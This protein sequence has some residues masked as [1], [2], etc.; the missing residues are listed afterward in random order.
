MAKRRGGITRRRSTRRSTCTPTT[1]SARRAPR[2]AGTWTSTT[3]S[4]RIPSTRAERRTRFTSQACEPSRR[5]LKRIARRA[6]R[7]S[8]P[9]RLSVFRREGDD[10]PPPWTTRDTTGTGRLD[11]SRPA[12][13]PN[14]L[15]HLYGGIQCCQEGTVTLPKARSSM[16][17]RQKLLKDTLGHWPA[18]MG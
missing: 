15:S 7:E 3:L 6:A 14:E 17:K 9:P 1:R 8:C 18:S 13:C 5:R 10:R 16:C 4:A 12:A 2:S 11:L